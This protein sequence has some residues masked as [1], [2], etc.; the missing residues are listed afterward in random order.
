MREARPL[1]VTR[2]LLRLIKSVEATFPPTVQLLSAARPWL[3]LRTEVE[4]LEAGVLRTLTSPAIPMH[5]TFTAMTPGSD[6]QDAATPTI[7]SIIPGS[8]D[9]F[10]VR[11][12]ADTSGVSVAV[13][14]AVSGSADSTSA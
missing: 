10:P 9:I 4:S 13:A 14:Q 12:A 1:P 7:I 8:T 6:T 11:L 3:Q 2:Q 5:R